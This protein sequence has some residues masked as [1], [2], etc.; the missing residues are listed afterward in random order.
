MALKYKP[1]RGDVIWVDFDGARG[2]EQRGRRPALVMSRDIYNARTLMA[3]VCPIT[4]RAK[5]YPLEVS[6]S[7][8]NKKG[9]ILADQIQSID[10]SERNIEF[11]QRVSADTTNE[12][13]QK[14]TTLVGE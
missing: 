11:I 13:W 2:H 10:L 8:Q 4:S 5:G 3:I 14:L 6:V 7:L 9:V 12:I 1:K